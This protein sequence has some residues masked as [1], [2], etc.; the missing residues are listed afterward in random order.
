MLKPKPPKPARELK[1]LKKPR[2]LKSI[3]AHNLLSRK[4]KGEIF[5]G[6]II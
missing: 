4:E 1:E 6:R 3:Y 5:D 2:K